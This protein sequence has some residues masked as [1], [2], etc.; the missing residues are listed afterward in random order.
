M[1]A[2]GRSCVGG[3]ER[4]RHRRLVVL[5][6]SLAP[7]TATVNAAVLSVSMFLIVYS[8]SRWMR[9]RLQPGDVNPSR[10]VSAS[11]CLLLGLALGCRKRSTTRSPSRGWVRAGGVGAHHVQRARAPRCRWA[12]SATGSRPR[13]RPAAPADRRAASWRA[14][15][16]GDHHVPPRKMNG[17][18][19]RWSAPGALGK[20][21]CLTWR[22]MQPSTA[23]SLM[24]VFFM[25]AF[26]RRRRAG[27]SSR[28]VMVPASVVLRCSSFS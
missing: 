18:V 17:I 26:R 12:R 25:L 16:E 13:A 4:R 5:H 10:W 2:S 15:T 7:S 22:M 27:S 24:V 8:S 14:A 20:T 1:S 9:S 11:S 28:S 3:R 6:H 19:A 23:A 21:H